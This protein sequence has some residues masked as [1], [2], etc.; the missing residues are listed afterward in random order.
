MGAD[1]IPEDNLEDLTDEL[2]G[3][4]AEIDARPHYNLVALFT[5]NGFKNLGD[6]NLSDYVIATSLKL[7]NSRVK[8]FTDEA[9]AIS[10]AIQGADDVAIKTIVESSGQFTLSNEQD[11]HGM[12][13]NYF[14]IIPK[15]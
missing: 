11:F 4:I 2:A 9:G 1:D 15:K 8:V 6:T 3:E 12:F 7:G 13:G 10:I 14:R 5:A